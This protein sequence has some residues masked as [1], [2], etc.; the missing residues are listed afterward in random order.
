MR[1]RSGPGPHA[2]KFTER[3]A[4]LGYTRAMKMRYWLA[5]C[6]LGLVAG[7]WAMRQRPRKAR[8]FGLRLRDAGQQPLGSAEGS[9]QFIGTATTIIRYGGITILTDPNFLHSGERV[10]IG[11]GMH[12]TRLTNPAINFEDLP[13]IDFVLLSHLHEDHF[14]K[15]VQERLPRDTPIVTTASAA[16][17]LR[18]MGFTRVCPL[19]RW[20][21]VVMRKGDTS[22]RVTAVPGTH[23]PMLVAAMLPDVMGSM[24]EFHNRQDEGRYRMYVS[25]DTL[26]F[27]DLKHIPRR[28]H[29]IDLALLH[30]GGTRVL[31]VLLTMDGEQGVQAL[32]VVNPE[33]AIPIHFDDYDVFRSPLAEFRRAVEREGLQA[34]VRY[35]ERG[36]TYSF[37]PRGAQRVAGEQPIV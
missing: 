15:L 12:S 32:R 19:R 3:R 27:K 37:A 23:G 11:Y 28:Y 1:I 31:G 20:D 5:G 10:H 30:L 21:R 24:L 6:A 16:R 35:L 36:E 14:D 9:V 8:I 13:A 17:A 4:A 29:E 25:G 33:L 22:L 2:R 7:V 34:K 26:A 18:R